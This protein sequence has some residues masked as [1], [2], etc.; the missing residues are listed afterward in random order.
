M[1]K[2]VM[3]LDESR[4]LRRLAGMD[5]GRE[6]LKEGASAHDIAAR[7]TPRDVQFALIRELAREQKPVSRGAPLSWARGATLAGVG[8]GGIAVLGLFFLLT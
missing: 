3:A 8:L 1:A 6:C 7:P 4:L 2:Q 5:S